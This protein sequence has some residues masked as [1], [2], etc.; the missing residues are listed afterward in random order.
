MLETRLSR[1]AILQSSVDG[2]TLD[3]SSIRVDAANREI[4]LFKVL[5]NGTKV[6]NQIIKL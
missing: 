6:S 4:K 5:I 3:C 2:T 1:V